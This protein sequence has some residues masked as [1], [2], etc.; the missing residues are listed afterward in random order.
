MND[1]TYKVQATN[2]KIGSKVKY[3]NGEYKILSFTSDGKSAYIKAFSQNPILVM[4]EFLG[5]IIVR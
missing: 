1:T 4:I 3:N 2:Y 5:V